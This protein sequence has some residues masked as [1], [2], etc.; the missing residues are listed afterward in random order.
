MRRD[1]D[2]IIEMREKDD[3]T[4][5]YLFAS[6]GGNRP[7]RGSDVIRRF[8]TDS[9]VANPKLFTWTT[10]RKQL[11]TITQVMEMTDTDQDPVFCLG[12]FCRAGR[13]AF[14]KKL[15]WRPAVCWWRP[16]TPCYI[17]LGPRTSQST[18]IGAETMCFPYFSIRHRN[19]T[20]I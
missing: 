7:Y 5:P 15:K 14:F 18:V 16:V 11:A 8:A 12:R 20:H 2:K 19:P 17:L 13:P 1:L 6:K 10:M 3:I 4:S 9:G